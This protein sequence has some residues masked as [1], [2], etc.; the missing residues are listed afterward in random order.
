MVV[1]LES[2]RHALGGVS[3]VMRMFAY[4]KIRKQQTCRVVA[5]NEPL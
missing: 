4:W 1:N 3:F 5:R 2:A